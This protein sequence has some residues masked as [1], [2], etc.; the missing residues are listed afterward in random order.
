LS[1]DVGPGQ[2]DGAD[3][4]GSRAFPPETGM[5][6][7]RGSK[8]FRR[9]AATTGRRSASRSGGKHLEP[10]RWNRLILEN[11]RHGTPGCQS[12]RPPPRPWPAA[13]FLWAASIQGSAAPAARD[14][15]QRGQ[16]SSTSGL[17]AFW[18]KGLQVAARG[19]SA[20][21]RLAVCFVIQAAP[22]G[23][24]ARRRGAEGSVGEGA[25]S[26]VG[27]YGFSLPAAS[28]SYSIRECPTK[29]EKRTR[30]RVPRV[31]LQPRRNGC[32]TDAQRRGRRGALRRP[33]AG[34]ILRRAIRR[35]GRTVSRT[36]SSALARAAAARRDP[37]A[38]KIAPVE[39][40]RRW[41]QNSSAGRRARRARRDASK[42]T[43]LHTPGAGC[44]RR[45]LRSKPDHR[46]SR[47]RA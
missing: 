8:A 34:T 31:Y 39:R 7:S 12:R 17:A 28:G 16:N 2:W 6:I 3:R 38:T 5:R 44:G 45:T 30:I 43:L 40:G 9:L 22:L 42:G 24:R 21:E 32:A 11:L 15:F 19:G 10:A 1:A 20:R 13:R 35:R 25:F 47:S 23:A 18:R 46:V 4:D 26:P 33:P 29:K 36:S 41:R 27:W 14:V 37:A